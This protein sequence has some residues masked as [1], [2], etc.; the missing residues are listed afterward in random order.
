MGERGGLTGFEGRS[1]GF[2]SQPSD[3]RGDVWARERDFGQILCRAYSAQGFHRPLSWSLHRPGGGGEGYGFG[4]D[5]DH[6]IGGSLFG[7][8]RCSMSDPH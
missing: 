5:D 3:K 7:L 4:V 6:E 2:T 1:N 8:L